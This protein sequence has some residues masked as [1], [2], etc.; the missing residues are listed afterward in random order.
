MCH[1]FESKPKSFILNTAL[2]F[3]GAILSNY[4]HASYARKLGHL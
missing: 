3:L 4:E 1:K 2:S